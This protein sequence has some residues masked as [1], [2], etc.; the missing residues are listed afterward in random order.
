MRL[1]WGSSWGGSGPEGLALALGKPP[2]AKVQIPTNFQHF[3]NTKPLLCV[4]TNHF[5][6]KNA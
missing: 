6:S 4:L 3:Y 2:G 1:L 5:F